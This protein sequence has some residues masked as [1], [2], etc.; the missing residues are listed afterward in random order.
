MSV[1][2]GRRAATTENYDV[3]YRLSNWL[4]KREN[5]VQSV[6]AFFVDVE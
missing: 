2:C 5:Y 4:Q 3:I 1:M 6:Q